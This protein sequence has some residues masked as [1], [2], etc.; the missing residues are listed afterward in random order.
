M[1]E[2]NILISRK[3]LLGFIAHLVKSFSGKGKIYLISQTTQLMEGWV[4]WI[5]EI[6]FS[7]NVTDP[8]RPDFKNS[9]ENFQK[10]NQIRIVEESPKEVIPLPE[11]YQSRHRE[12]STTNLS[13]NGKLKIYH[14]DPYSV[15]F[16]YIARGDEQDYHMVLNFLEHG[17]INEEEMNQM[18]EELLPSFSF[19]TIQQD[20][21]EF[22]RRYKGLLQM[23]HSLE[24]KSKKAKE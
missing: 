19:Q 1:D 22:R 2:R 10:E 8:D 4:N 13:L 5:E 7:A 16:R 24:G 6:E 20:P 14:F 15:A 9:I 17:W 11:G 3:I 23:W 21:A 18:L 12:V